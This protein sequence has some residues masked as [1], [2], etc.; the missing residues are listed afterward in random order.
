MASSYDDE[1]FPEPDYGTD[2]PYPGHS[3][4]SDCNCDLCKY[5]RFVY[6][7]DRIEAERTQKDW[8]ERRE[9]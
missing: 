3:V 5:E 6:F 4:R 2:G 8:D 9:T 7:L 1:D